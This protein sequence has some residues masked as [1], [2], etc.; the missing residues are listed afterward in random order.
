GAGVVA[1]PLFKRLGFG[2][3]L[4]YL[5]AGIIIGPFGLKV[6]T[7]SGTILHIAE[8]GVI[9]FLFIIGLEMRPRRLWSMKRDIFGLGAAQV[10]GCGAFMTLVGLAFGLPPAVAFIGAMGFVLSSTAVIMQ[11]LEEKGEIARPPGQR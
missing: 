5:T 11:T 10:A 9:M 2:S 4:G 3:I 7:E 6:L 1:G 8:L